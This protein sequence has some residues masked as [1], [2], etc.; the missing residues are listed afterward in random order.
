MR[1][2]YILMLLMCYACLS[3]NMED[4][5]SISHGP[6]ITFMATDP[7]TKAFIEDINRSGNQ[8]VVYDYMTGTDK[9]LDVKERD[10]WY[11][12]HLRIQCTVD[13][14]EVWDY[15]DENE[16]FWLYGSHHNCFGWLLVGP[17]GYNTITFFGEHPEFD[18]ANFFLTSST[19]HIYYGFPFIRL[20]V[21]RCSEK[22]IHSAKSG[23]VSCHAE[24][25]PS[26]FCIQIHYT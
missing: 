22:I 2:Y 26:L 12:D 9:I 19:L 23:F 24:N 18:K 8:V 1:R 5:G 4:K 16:Y 25:E 14:Q 3:C 7:Q 11:I 10:R 13:G 6:A 20:L 15:V 17:S 21:F